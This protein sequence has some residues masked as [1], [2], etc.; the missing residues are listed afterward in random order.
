MENKLQELTHKLYEE[1][2]VKGR[3]EAENLLAKAQE[4][5]N[6]L[7]EQ[8]KTQAAAI[9]AGAQQE[10]AEHIEQV[11]NEIRM[12]SRQT[13]ANLKR[14]IEN[15]VVFK[16]VDGAT[17]QAMSDKDFVQR[18]IQQ[19]VA[20][21]NPKGSDAIDLNVVLPQDQ[22]DDFSTFLKAQL[23]KIF[24]SNVTVTFAS[25]VENGFTIGPKSGSY[26]IRFTDKDFVALFSQY[27]RPKTQKLLYGE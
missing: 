12:A 21:F 13:L 19:L 16:A 1:G 2:L 5:A 8:A 24:D 3:T 23:A 25:T 4:D 11:D 7:I 6:A 26:Q 18:L 9:I 10:A 27:L 15:I 17:K 20:S 22:K 14:Q